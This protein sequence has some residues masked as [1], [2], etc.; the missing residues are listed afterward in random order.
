MATKRAFDPGQMRQLLVFTRP[1]N[2]RNLSGGFQDAPV[3]VF[4]VRGKL[5]GLAVQSYHGEQFALVDWT[6]A[7]A[8]YKA[9]IRRRDD[10]TSDMQ[11]VFGTRVFKIRECPQVGRNENY[12][13]ILCEEVTL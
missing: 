3:P 13:D 6:T 12:M 5:E 1:T 7:R 9:T 11:I 8:G 4:R 2:P 10:V